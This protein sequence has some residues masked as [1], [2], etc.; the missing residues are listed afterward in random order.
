MDARVLVQIWYIMAE[1]L[2]QGEG[3]SKDEC[4]KYVHVLILS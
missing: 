3:S 2:R 1:I 4:N